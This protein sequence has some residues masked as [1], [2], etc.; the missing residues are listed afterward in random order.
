MGSTRTTEANIGSHLEKPHKMERQKLAN[1]KMNMAIDR[2]Y[3]VHLLQTCST[4][5]C[6]QSG[7]R[8]CSRCSATVG[9]SIGC[10]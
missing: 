10:C 3:F 4:I 2:G 8:T 9:G 5:R 6:R 7:A 1:L